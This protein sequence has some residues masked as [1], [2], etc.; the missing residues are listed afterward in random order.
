MK[1]LMT[2][3]MRTSL[4]CTFYALLMLFLFPGQYSHA[5]DASAVDQIDFSSSRSVEGE[6]ARSAERPVE[7]PLAR[8]RERKERLEDSFG[9]TYGFDNNTQYLGTDSNRSPSDAASNVF[10][11]YGTWSATGRGTPNNG[12]MVFKIEN[13]SALGD[14]ISPQALG[15]SLD[16]AGLF[17]STF[18]DSGTVLTN[19]YWRQR[20]VN[21]RAAFVV[22]QVDATDYVSVNNL[23]N[24]WTAFTN[25]G[26]EQPPTLPAP[27][28]GLGAAFKWRLDDNWAILSGFADANA[29]PSK[30]FDSARDFFD[31]R[32]TFKH[33]AV[34]WSPDWGD[35]V[36][37]LSQLTIWQVDDRDHAGVEGGH[38]V[39]FTASA[40]KDN[41]LPFLR[42][43]YAKDAGATLE[44]TISIGN[45]YEIRG[46]NDLAG[47]GVNWG[48]APDS[49]RDQYTLEAFYRYDMLDFLQL[50]PQ[51][52]YVINPAFDQTTND[53]LVLGARL[54]AFF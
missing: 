4:H 42:I 10:R 52:Q 2:N 27:S 43:G 37:Q 30:P 23:A 22:G 33:L 20:L 19:L 31:K 48:R 46:G 5:E 40:R 3:R 49:S 15:P 41:W 29:D 35:S 16:Y 26:F 34:G 7:G 21:G 12:A 13:R 17:S 54:R 50:T 24:P 38:G 6:L 32:E 39:D 8:F 28:Q 36:N 14:K 53:I 47:I 11:I 45:G 51:I 9:L 1:T 44:R 25:L 18:S